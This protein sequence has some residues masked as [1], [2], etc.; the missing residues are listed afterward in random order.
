MTPI[1][2]SFDGGFFKA[3]QMPV[4]AQPWRWAPHS[5]AQEA[6]Q[7]WAREAADWLSAQGADARD[8]LVVLPVGAVLS[9]AR[10]AWAAVVG[11]WV[12][13]IDTIASV[14]ESLAWAWVPGDTDDGAGLPPVTLDAV[15]DRLQAARSLGREAWGKQWAQRD[16]RGFEFA[17]DQVV[18]AAQTWVRRMQAIAPDERG[19]Y[20]DQARA[21][22]GAGAGAASQQGPGGR[23]RLLLAWALEWAAAT[24]SGGLPID[25]LYALRPSA[26]L[27]VTA[28]QAVSPG[29]EGHLTLG[30]MA[31][32]AGQG[33]PVNW[34]S[35]SAAS[36]VPGAP[37]E[38]PPVLVPCRDG[39]DEA[40]QAAAQ[41]I[42]AVNFA[43]AR[44]ASQPVALIA[45]DRS[46]IRRVR[47][48][49]EGAGILMADE[50][51][52]LLSTTRAAAVLT[53]LLQASHP[54][55]ATDDL[56][57]W[58]KSG[59]LAWAVGEGATSRPQELSLDM[60]A[61]RLEAWCR[62]HGMLGAWGLQVPP[63]SEAPVSDAVQKVPTGKEA[64]PPSA[65]HLWHWALQAVEPL[66]RLWTARKP[67]L[68]DWLLALR[69]AL[70]RSGALAVLQGDEAGALALDA[71]RFEALEA[72]DASLDAPSGSA[73]QAGGGMWAGLSTQT[74]LDGAAFAR[75]VGMVLES[76][77]FRPPSPAQAADVVITPM[78]RAVLRPFDA[79]VLP[80]A[81]E[82]QLGA[83]GSQSGWLGVKL[84]EAMDLA[85]PA[86]Q[87]AAQWD[88][89]SLLMSRPGV[90]CLYRQAQGSEP[91]EA[92]AW[93]ERWSAQEGTPIA[94][95]PDAREA[96]P[97]V[98]T[99]V[100]LP[101]PS[102]RDAPWA[103]PAQVS[104]TSYDALRQCPYRFF[105]TS[106][107][108]L[109]EQDELE[110]G[111]DRSDF[112]IWLHEVLRSFHAQRQTQLALSTLEEDVQ[113]WLDAAHA[114][115]AEQGLDRDS[116]RPYFL[117]FQADLD[118]MAR[119]YVQ[120]LRGH[121]DEGWR[122]RDAE[123]QERKALRVNDE[124]VVDL[125]GQLDRIDVRWQDGRKQRMVIDYKTGSADALK[126]KVAMPLED[127]QLAFYAALSE[128]AR[129]DDTAGS[130]QDAQEVAAA[131]LHLDAQAVKQFEHADV[132]HSAQVLL[133]GLM[134]D[135]ERLHAGAPM[136]ALG[137][138]SACAY[139]QARGLC[140]KD[141]WAAQEAQ[142]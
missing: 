85:T 132:V 66:Q 64:M 137:E 52:W 126:R 60:A 27:V 33:V 20:L 2:N 110:E 62:R 15:V 92:S 4:S 97:L 65:V 123:L 48:M 42:A 51:G 54:R 11:G 139:C 77:T 131:Y 141:H 105:A 43:R 17:L 107:L 63:V 68:Q 37:R 1:G 118:S 102:L 88:A 59:W 10:Q 89:F 36:P 23:E 40:Q 75:W 127:T 12:P 8:A 135:W 138:G 125:Y 81:D 29:T 24:A 142:P 61:G 104:A 117:P 28:G 49:L 96:R 86:T 133:D 57:D 128:P 115:I 91:L 119:A 136:P 87:R 98:R 5:G 79:I 7:A 44:A 95:Q 112:G 78:A 84:R 34:H 111:L 124:L 101:Q 73:S 120:W 82:R 21:A 32:L 74:R 122:V 53:R 130:R 94:R 50:T 6:W 47:A 19:A 25:P 100:V 109:R 3:S 39:E 56:L 116:Q 106:V 18:E 72:L 83:M 41:V 134:R 38:R 58:L 70:A 22:L 55:A 129:A 14:A 46:L 9:Q 45:L 35:A 71:L 69:E 121:E 30:L 76:T 140:R 80:G 103:L 67:S 13:R 114:V 31:H 90:V 26:L 93:L 108:G 16:R 113:A 99:P